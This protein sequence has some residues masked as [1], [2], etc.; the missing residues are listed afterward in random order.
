MNFP[1]ESCN[2]TRREAQDFSLL[3]TLLAQIVG[4]MLGIFGP[5]ALLGA[6]EGGGVDG[7]PVSLGQGG[8]QQAVDGEGAGEGIA[9]PDRVGYGDLRRGQV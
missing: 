7:S 1:S 9:G 6:D 4:D 2:L 5:G 8:P 3:I